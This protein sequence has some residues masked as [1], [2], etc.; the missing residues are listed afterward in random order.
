MGVDCEIYLPPDVRIYD[1]ANV[2]GILVGNEK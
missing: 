1:V 2:M